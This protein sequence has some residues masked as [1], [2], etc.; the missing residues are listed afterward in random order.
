MRTPRGRE[1]S[2]RSDRL[3]PRGFRRSWLEVG[4][5]SGALKDGYARVHDDGR[6]FSVQRRRFRLP[7]LRPIQRAAHHGTKDT[8]NTEVTDRERQ[9]RGIDVG[10]RGQQPGTGLVDRVQIKVWDGKWLSPQH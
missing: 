10:P 9:R 3:H 4:H 8:T 2:V 7:A 1:R 5:L 6:Y